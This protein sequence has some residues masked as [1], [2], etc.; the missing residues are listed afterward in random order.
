MMSIDAERERLEWKAISK[1]LSCRN[2]DEKAD[3][4]AVFASTPLMHWVLSELLC[5]W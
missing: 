4:K 5:F 2:H 1:R 3:L